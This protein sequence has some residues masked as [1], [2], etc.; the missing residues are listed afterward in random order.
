MRQKNWSTVFRRDWQ[1]LMN[2][3]PFVSVLLW[4]YNKYLLYQCS[5]VTNCWHVKQAMLSKKPQPCWHFRDSPETSGFV[6][7]FWAVVGPR[8]YNF[9]KDSSVVIL[10][11]HLDLDLNWECVPTKSTPHSR[12]CL[13]YLVPLSQS[14]L[15]RGY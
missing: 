13:G 4:G 5:S 8:R 14:K 12:D 2:K 9:E 10:A 1:I 6:V 7:L 15:T 3:N 11:D